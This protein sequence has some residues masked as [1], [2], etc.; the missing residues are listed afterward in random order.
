MFALGLRYLNGWAM[1]AADGAGKQRAEWPPHPDRVFMALAAAWFETGRAEEERA[2]LLWLERLP[3]PAIRAA[4]ATF[5]SGTGGGGPVVGYVP[6]N[7]TELG[8]K[9]PDTHDPGR[10][11]EAGLG[12]L[13]EYRSRQPRAFPVAIPADPDVYLS[14]D[15]GVPEPHRAP[16]VS[17]CRKVISV[18][19]SASLVQM[20]LEDSPPAADWVPVEGLGAHRLRVSGTGRLD[21][22]ERRCNRDQVIAWGGLVARLAEASK[23][24]EKKM[25]KE[26]LSDRFPNGRPVSLRP[27]PGMWQAYG[28]PEQPADERVPGQSLFDPHLLVLALD[29]QRPS[30]HATLK[31]TEAL[32]G[33]TL[34]ACRAP[35]AAIPEWLSG[36]A[37]DG[38]ATALPHVALLPPPFVDHDHADG[39]VMGLALALPRGLDPAE[40]A[41][42]LEPWLRDGHG[43]P[44]S[45]SLFDGRWLECRAE[46]E[47]RARPPQK[48]LWAEAW[49]RP[50]R[51]WA[52]VT[53]VVLDRHC[54]GKDRWE[55]AAEVVKDACERIGLPRP[56]DVLLH[57]DSLIRGVPRA[58]EFPPLARKSDG[59]PCTTP[60][61]CSCSSGRCAARC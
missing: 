57:P 27:V 14:W 8:R 58:G 43:L 47:T 44:A 16:L 1:A 22:L 6:V 37:A 49:T 33:A 7:D 45:L 30:L 46:L 21:D 3:P 24:K 10:L 56:L 35:G 51:R 34:A 41:A 25:L 50:S 38:R 36:H 32:R 53:P 4:E 12:L 2:V 26:Q 20:W 40:A 52:S 9:T 31:L 28:R 18:G 55:K 48:S 11:K 54:G 39:R 13:P 15:G 59:G 61:P 29:G 5:R 60:M 19:H 17:L 23:S 42:I